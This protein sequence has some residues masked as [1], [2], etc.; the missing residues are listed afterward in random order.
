MALRLSKAILIW[1][2]LYWIWKSKQKSLLLRPYLE[3]PISA[4]GTKQL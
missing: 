4:H 3:K 2:S 1:S